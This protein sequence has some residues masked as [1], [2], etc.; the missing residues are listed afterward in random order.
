[1]I[2]KTVG[3]RLSISE[4][5]EAKCIFQEV[6]KLQLAGSIVTFGKLIFR[7]VSNNKS[8]GKEVTDKGL[9]VKIAVAVEQSIMFA[10]PKT[11]ILQI[12]KGLV[13]PPLLSSK[14]IL[15]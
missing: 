1:M 10:V 5:S 7:E 14:L 9:S 13:I 8:N 11:A 2:K 4:S 3:T 12:V 6:V 15:T